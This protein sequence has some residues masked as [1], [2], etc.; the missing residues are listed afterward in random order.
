MAYEID[1]EQQNVTHIKVIGVGGGGGNAVNRM[2]QAG[3]SG[4]ELIAVNTDRQMLNFSKATQKIQIGEADERA[5]CRCE[6]RDR[7]KGGGGK[8]RRDH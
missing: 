6:A 8:P 2:A 3:F 5:G 1:N 7:E 4:I